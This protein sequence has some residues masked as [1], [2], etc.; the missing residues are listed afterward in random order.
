MGD[1]CAEDGG[2]QVPASQRWEGV[3]PMDGLGEGSFKG[4]CSSGFAT[5]G[6]SR[7][8]KEAGG[9]ASNA[10]H[11]CFLKRRVEFREACSLESSCVPKRVGFE[12]ARLCSALT[13]DGRSGSAIGPTWLFDQRPF[14]LGLKNAQI[15]I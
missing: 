9:N 10:G 13:R 2:Y 15:S 1:G 5:G 4:L 7:P 8:F 12:A 6:G 3:T 14:V 11:A